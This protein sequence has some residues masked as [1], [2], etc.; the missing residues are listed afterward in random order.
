[1]SKSPAQIIETPGRAQ[2]SLTKAA[3]VG[4]FIHYKPLSVFSASSF[5]QSN[6]TPQAFSIFQF[7]SFA[8]SSTIMR[9]RAA[10]LASRTRI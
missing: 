3:L 1:L 5:A 4:G 9:N 2:A 8:S 10:P 6:R 7:E